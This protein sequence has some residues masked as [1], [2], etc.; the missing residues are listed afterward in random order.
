[1]N[2][3]SSRFILGDRLNC[4]VRRSSSQFPARD[5]LEAESILEARTTPESDVL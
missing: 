4:G 2:G 1:M 3:G 5:K